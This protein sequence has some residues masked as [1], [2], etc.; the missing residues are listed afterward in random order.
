VGESSLFLLYSG[1]VIDVESIRKKLC[2]RS[3][4]LVK[5][6]MAVPSVKPAVAR[7]SLGDAPVTFEDL[8]TAVGRSR[9][10]DAFIRLF[11]HFAPR[12][13][14]FLMRGG[15][16]ADLAD[17]LA[18]ET[19]L[20]VWDKAAGYNAAQAAASTWIYTI[21]RNKR[22]D[23]LRRINRPEPDA[24]DPLFAP[25]PEPRPD[26][27]LNHAEEATYIAE[28]MKKLPA[29][30]A[31]LIQKAFFEEKSH[32]DIAAETNLPLGTVKSRI[33]LALDRMRQGLKG[34][35]A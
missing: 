17:E 20:T 19:M 22:I 14:S 9:D 24:A 26:D 11:E 35:A 7:L 8:L 12:V 23:S 15:F 10:R 30:Q 6:R 5:C 2:P 18:Q 34:V 32:S 31:E 1:Y 33:R 28:A 3:G 25:E 4:K 29:E 16:R 27:I 13:K 21:A